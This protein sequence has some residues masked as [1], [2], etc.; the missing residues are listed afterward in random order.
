M[1]LALFV[2]IDLAIGLNH[3]RQREGDRTAACTGFDDAHARMNVQAQDEIA[4]LLGVDDLGGATDV[5]DE[6]DRGRAEEHKGFA[7]PGGDAEPKSYSS[8]SSWRM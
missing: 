4:N 8:R 3:A 7:E 1:L 2:S 6:V 5:H